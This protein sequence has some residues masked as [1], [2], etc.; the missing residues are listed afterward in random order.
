M[1]ILTIFGTRPETIKLAPIILE[2]EQN[3]EDFDLK[4]VVTGQHRELLDQFLKIFEIK[5]DYD[6]CAM[7]E[8]QS[9]SNLSAEILKRVDNILIKERP[10]LVIVQGDTTSAFI[11]SLTAFYHKI[12]IA[13]VEAGLRTKDKYN[14]FPEEINRRVIDV[15]S[16]FYFTPTKIAK[17]NLINEGFDKRK[18]FITGNTVIDALLWMAKKI[19]QPKIDKQILNSF[20]KKYQIPFDNK[21]IILVTGHRR[22][23]FGKDF[24]N[25]CFGLK[26]IVEEN[27]DVRIIYPMH[28]NPNVRKPVC[29]ILGKVNR[30]HLMPPLDYPEFIWLMNRSYFIMTDSGGIQE[31]APSLHKPVLVMRKK[32]ERPE[33]LKAG[34]SK[35]AG[36]TQNSILKTAQKL[37]KDEKE[38]QKMTRAQNPYGD[39]KAAKRIVNI[40][41]NAFKF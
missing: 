39:G 29:K 36:V 31:E 10:G 2:M 21:K 30:V 33:G 25:I 11:G 1:K 38:Y 32:T 26:K 14:P 40:L 6:L 27:P 22:E 8:N 7:K 23:S 15:L 19:S 12:K 18:I 34:V 16:D 4:I 37:I 35:L 20:Q 17:E 9:L 3:P 5:P 41:K 24:E 13:H 28:L